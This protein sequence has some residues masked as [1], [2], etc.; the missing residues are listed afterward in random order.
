MNNVSLVDGHIDE[1]KMT[2]EE[3][4][5][6]LE[7]CADGGNRCDECPY[8]IGDCLDDDHKSIMLE[9]ALELI[10]R[11]DAEIDIILRK[12]EKLRDLVAEQQAEIER[13]RRSVMQA[14]SRPMHKVY[15]ADFVK[16]KSLLFKGHR[17]SAI[18]EFAE[19]IKEKSYLNDGV[20][21]IDDL[22]KEM[23]GD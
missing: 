10:N 15:N 12:K 14:R 7:C 18:K 19:R 6:A 5:K 22:V 2:D 16:Y 13:L 4:K 17:E 23:V 20:V 21:C 3:I 11:K 9:D 8:G 1:P